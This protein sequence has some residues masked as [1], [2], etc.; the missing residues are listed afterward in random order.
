VNY[1]DVIILLAR[2]RSGTNPLRS[3]LESHPDIYCFTELFWVY[4][5]DSKFEVVRRPNFFYFLEQYAK[6]D[7]GRLFPDR[8]EKLF[9]DFLEYLRCFSSKRYILIDVKYNTTHFFTKPWADNVTSPY[10]LDLITNYQLRVL[11]VTRKNYLRYVLSELKAFESGTYHITTTH[12]SQADQKTYVDIPAMFNWFA[13]CQAEDALI[14]NHF[15]SY[16]RFLTF[17]YVDLFRP[18][19]GEIAP[20]FL[21]AMAQW[22]DLPKTF[23]TAPWYKK[24][25]YLP[26]REAIE[27]YEEVAAS[28]AGTEYEQFL[29]DEPGYSRSKRSKSTWI[30]V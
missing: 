11:N 22:L 8:H 2:Q 5:K 10:L 20:T 28:L 3:I 26:L 1:S 30:V 9:L 14:E 27:N 21:K 7:V 4:D 6:G 13:K 19:A 23:S 18:P 16:P 17:E 25:T 29:D 15:Q 24:Q 12:G